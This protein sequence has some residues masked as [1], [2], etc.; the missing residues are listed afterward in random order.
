MRKHVGLA[1]V[2]IA[3]AAM[4]GSPR[5][6]AQRAD[7][8][9]VPVL[10]VDGSTLVAGLAPAIPSSDAGR[11]RGPVIAGPTIV[12]RA[13]AESATPGDAASIAQAGT[14]MPTSRVLIIGGTAAAL[15]GILIGGDAGAIVAVTGTVGAVYGLYLHYR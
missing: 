4:A 9:P 8:H 6:H 11:S 14:R 13:A 2:A 7:G 12:T 15:A 3:L 10:A 1:L 5:A